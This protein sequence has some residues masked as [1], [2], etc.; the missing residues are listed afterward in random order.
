MT[1]WT[2]HDWN[3]KRVAL[4][5]AVFKGKEVSAGVSV[6]PDSPSLRTESRT[7]TLAGNQG[8]ASP[9]SPS[10]R[11]RHGSKSTQQAQRAGRGRTN[12][13]SEAPSLG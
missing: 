5:D 1:A 12:E 7:F 9:S 8:C 13:R 2:Y 6:L 11:W 4:E 10:S 3:G